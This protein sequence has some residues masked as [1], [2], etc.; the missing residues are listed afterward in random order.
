MGRISTYDITI[1][2]EPVSCNFPCCV[3]IVSN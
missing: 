1:I 3:S 2:K